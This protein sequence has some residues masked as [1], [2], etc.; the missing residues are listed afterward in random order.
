[1]ADDRKLAHFLWGEQAQHEQRK[2]HLRG[3]CHGT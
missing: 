2:R 3:K 1:L